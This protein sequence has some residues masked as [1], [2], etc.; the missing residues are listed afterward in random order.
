M[1]MF[2]GKHGPVR[3]FPFEKMARQAERLVK[4]GFTVYQKFSCNGCGERLTMDVPNKFFQ[5]GTC[6]KCD[7]V[8]NI[9]RK[10][11][12]YCVTIAVGIVGGRE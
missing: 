1:T 3:D 4:D 8:T 12:N 7:T 10:G 2:V 5:E 9:E 6:D 11:C